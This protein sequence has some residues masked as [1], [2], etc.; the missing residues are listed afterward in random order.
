MKRKRAVAT[1]IFTDVAFILLLFFLVFAIASQ[2]S[3]FPLDLPLAS[4]AQDVP[5]AA[6]RIFVDK[7]GTLYRV[8]ESKKVEK[9]QDFYTVTE[10]VVRDLKSG[11]KTEM[12][13]T[14]VQY[15]LGLDDDLFSERYL[16]RPP[17]EA[18]R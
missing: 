4:H 5:P 18:M 10:S 6:V 7:N 3:P 1:A 16:R 14:D 17:R 13:F 15:N 9:I 2:R 11:G 8:I 12:K